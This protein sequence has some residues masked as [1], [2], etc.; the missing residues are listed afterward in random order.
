MKKFKLDKKTSLRISSLV[1]LGALSITPMTGCTKKANGDFNNPSINAMKETTE[2]GIVTLFP[3]MNEEI[4]ENSSIIILLDDIAKEDENGKINADV[5]SEFKSKV[6]SSNMMNDFNSF[7]NVLEQTMIQNERVISTNSFVSNN[8]KTILSKIEKITT[9]I[10]NGNKET[11]RTNFDL[12]YQLVVEEKEI[13]YDG[14]TFNLRDL[15]YGERAIAGAYARTCAYF[16]KE[17]ITEEEYAKIDERTND[18]N[19][20]AFIKTDL[21]ILG[22]QIVEK[23]EE[24]VEKIFNTEYSDTKGAFA[25]R[26]NISDSNI[27]NLVNYI[28]LE[29]LDSDKVSNKD[30]KEVLGTYSDEAVSNTLNA[31][32]A[33]TE[34]NTNNTSNIILIS[35]MLVDSYKETTTGKVDIVTLDYIQFNTI[36][37]LNTTTEASTAEEI[38]NNP[39][40]QNIYQYFRKANFVHDYSNTNSVSINYQDISDGAK[41][42]AN[43]MVYYTLSKRPNVFKYEGYE[44]KINLN[45]VESI[46]Y[47]QNVV[48]GECK[49]IDITDFVKSK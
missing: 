27:I 43:E 2:K 21:E 22:N 28:N 25:G 7:L 35:S 44:E 32:D 23:S 33:I 37:L 4:V 10:I 5:I 6:D 12:I 40:F 26:I 46:Q 16:A 11:K 47:I 38:F 49:K 34:Y 17:Y 13:T 14:L 29:Y 30:K 31:I 1:L 19:N 39:Y 48:T 3:T 41:F 20:K 45:L 9:N 36:K 8:D 24:D 42:V 18:Q 15:G